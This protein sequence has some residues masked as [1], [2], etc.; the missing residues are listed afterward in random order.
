M[1]KIQLDQARKF[2][3]NGETEA[4]LDAIKAALEN[5]HANQSVY[6]DQLVLISAAYGQFQRKT[7]NGTLAGTEASVEAARINERALE[8]IQN[9]AEGRLPSVQKS[10]YQIRVFSVLALAILALAGAYWFYQKSKLIC[11]QYSTEAKWKVAVLPLM[12][13]GE[14]LAKPEVIISKTINELT[15]NN[16][17]SV[18]AVIWDENAQKMQPDQQQAMAACGTDLLVSGEY[19]VL[20]TDSVVVS[21][22]YQFSDKRPPITTDFTG[23]SNVTALREGL[24]EQ[25]TMQDAIFSLCTILAMRENNSAL[26]DKWLKKIKAPMGWEKGMVDKLNE[27]K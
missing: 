26:A 22:T 2:L 24:L 20:N 9:I 23:F 19:L 3:A 1:M 12:N 21:L 13:L 14:R 7:L 8:L 18:Q 27:I 6:H 11:P 25:R 16:K 10:K 17:L 5:N 4:C 15:A